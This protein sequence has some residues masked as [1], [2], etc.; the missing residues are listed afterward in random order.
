M[1]F[2]LRTF[3]WE[4]QNYDFCWL[5][6]LD[7][8]IF[9]EH[10]TIL[11][12]SPW[13]DLSNGV[14][15][16][17]IGD[18]LIPNLKEFVI[19]SLILNYLTFSLSFE[20]NSCKSSLNEQCEGT[21][22]IYTSRPFQWYYKGLIWCFFSFLNKALNIQDS[23]TSTTPKMGMHLR[24]IGLHPLHSPHLRDCVSHPN[25]LFWPHGSLHST[26]N[27]EPNVKVATLMN[28]TRPLSSHVFFKI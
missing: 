16:A 25:T 26:F 19:E 11:S 4:S 10:A 23:H 14:L 27:C 7:V 17:S 3:K 6:T 15:H 5:E 13:K 18:H 1:A 24:V 21:L 22:G 28:W 20:R 9:L 2:F 8:H 12:Y